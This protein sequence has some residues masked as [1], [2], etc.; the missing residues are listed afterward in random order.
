MQLDLATAPHDAAVTADDVLLFAESNSR[1]IVEVS[2][3][4]QE[5]F[6]RSM[7]GVPIGCVGT[8]IEG[9]DFVVKGIDGETVVQ[10]TIDQLKENWQATFRW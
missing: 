7:A 9:T 6:E 10:T 3:G 8:V 5:E 2:P 1:F 4:H